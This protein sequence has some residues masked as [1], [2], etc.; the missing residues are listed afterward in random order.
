[1]ERNPPLPTPAT[2]SSVSNQNI[3]NPIRD[4]SYYQTTVITPQSSQTISDSFQKLVNRSEFSS[5]VKVS[6]SLND[7][8]VR[9]LWEGR[10]KD[11]LVSSGVK[12]SLNPVTNAVELN[13]F[14]ISFSYAS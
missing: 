12:V 3:I 8:L 11:F 2:N 7:R 14:G 9:L 5:V 6:T 4:P 13:R 1:V 10:F